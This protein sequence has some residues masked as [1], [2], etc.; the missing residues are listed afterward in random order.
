MGHLVGDLKGDEIINESTDEDVSN[1][2][3]STGTEL[4]NVMIVVD[5][6]SHT[7]NRVSE[8]LI[9][10]YTMTGVRPSVLSIWSV[11]RPEGG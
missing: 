2:G 6:I 7:I 3:G 4:I 11:G 1:V 8:K 9:I 5:D 10:H